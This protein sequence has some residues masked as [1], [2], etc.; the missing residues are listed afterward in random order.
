MLG[1]LFG[2]AIPAESASEIFYRVTG[3]VCTTHSQA[4]DPGLFERGRRW[5]TVAEDPEGSTERV[6][7]ELASSRIDGSVDA[8]GA[9]A[10]LEW[11]LV[12][13]NASSWQQE[14][15]AELELPPN[16]VVSRATLWIDGEPRE[17][18]F[19]SRAQARQ[20]YERVVSRRKDPL[21][22]TSTGRGRVQVRCFPVP[23]NGEMKIRL[24]ISAPLLIDDQGALLSLPGMSRRNFAPGRAHQVWL[25]AKQPFQLGAESAR[26]FSGGFRVDQS[27]PQTAMRVGEVAARFERN[28]VLD[29]AWSPDPTDAKHIVTQSVEQYRPAALE[30]VS[31]VLDGSIQQEPA[32]KALRA[33]LPDFATGAELSL[34]V[35]SD[36]GV[37]ELV[38]PRRADKALLAELDRA[39][40]ELE[41]AGGADN[42]PAVAT[43][44]E[45][46]GK[47][48]V[49]LWLHGPQPYLFEHPERVRQVLE[50][51]G[52]GAK[53]FELQTVPGANRVVEAL[54][55]APGFEALE[56]AGGLESALRR[57][58]RIWSGAPTYRYNREQR[59]ASGELPAGHKTSEHLARL[60]AYQEIERLAGAGQREPALKLASAHK[61][62]TSVS[63]AVVLETA[64]QYAEA[65]LTPPSM[66]NVPS[67]PEPAFWA[68]LGC[69]LLL[70]VLA[71][72][73]SRRLKVG[74][75]ACS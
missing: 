52:G 59:A 50:R 9:V 27:L 45:R 17:A 40:S 3:R 38:A 65:G 12:L 60:W 70:L 5:S 28:S 30:Q 42:V 13:H 2:S 49:V 37:I 74:E 72:W 36:G 22:V 58:F 23:A 56:R 48:G 16:A 4:F 26:A 11:T 31:I 47:R 63:G 19:A 6:D 51:S 53:L 46:V 68:L 34:I 21:L 73:F 10:Y 1:F 18:A 64:T 35:A 14:A 20:A 54:E 69:A 25:E 66:D 67:V 15:T 61:L 32:T 71:A 24:G 43:A 29:G 39:L 8:A 57:T 7:L 44:L 55:G 41:L 33:A 75:V 62:V